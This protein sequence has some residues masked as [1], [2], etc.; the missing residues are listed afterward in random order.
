MTENSGM[1]VKK[2][3]LDNGVRVITRG[4]PHI[5]SVSMGVWV[6]VGARDESAEESGLSH[7]IEHMIF[8]GT[9]RRSAY[10]IAK[11]F[12]VIGG[13]TN[14]FT[15]M[16]TTCYHA[17]VMDDHL[18]T[19]TDI[20]SDILLNSVFDDREVEKERPVIFQEIGMVEDAPDEYIHILSENAYWGEHP[21]G[22]SVLGAREN[23]IRFDAE[24]IKSF[25]RRAYQPEGI[26]IAAAGNLEHQRFL[27]LVAP[28][29]STVPAQ[30]SLPERTPARGNAQV[31]VHYRDLEQ[32]HV[33]LEAGGV[34]V[35]DPRRYSFSLLN[36]ILGG[37]M[38][39]RLFQ[40][41]REN[42]GLAYSIYSYMSSYVDSGMFG[43]YTAVTQHQVEETVEVML[44]ELARIQT[45]PVSTEELRDAKEYTRGS[46]WLSVEN[47]D[48]QMVRL[49]QNEIHFSKFITM[50]EVM[51]R[52]EAVTPEDILQLAQTL[53]VPD[54]LALTF[55]GPVTNKG[56]LEAL[57]PR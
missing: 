44:S 3:R 49:A 50:D 27:D 23:V 32:V 47:V 12:D 5:R 9:T 53:F 10:Q 19:M 24:A 34:S 11:E 55:L 14:A 16:E 54:S 41:V 42:R 37:N 31:G 51:A 56:P 48:S 7:F 52:V 43:I 46:L 21:L 17:K 26:V 39:S 57:L 8:K 28:T 33:C 4:I 29:F 1:E 35:T 2:T 38:S 45:E 13:H 6:D 40:E 22:R 36:T 18:P 15:S 25:F 20:L 30:R